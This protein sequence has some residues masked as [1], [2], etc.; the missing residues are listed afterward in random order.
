MGTITELGTSLDKPDL[1]LV[2]SSTLSA[3]WDRVEEILL[4]KGGDRLLSYYDPHHVCQLI[5]SGWIDLWV[6]INRGEVELALLMQFHV[7]P[8]KKVYSTVWCGG[9]NVKAY[10]PRFEKVEQFAVVQGAKEVEIIGRTGW[11]RL[12]PEY[13]FL[14][15][16]IRRNVARRWGH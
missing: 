9:W 4:E 10:V 2:N 7:Y 16:T 14:S 6:G 15:M 13:D 8:K 3:V 11:S 5:Y 1:W 12:F